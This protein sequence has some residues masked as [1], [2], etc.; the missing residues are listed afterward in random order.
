MEYNP[1]IELVRLEENFEYG[2]FGVLKINKEVFCPTLEPRDE[3]NSSFNS[4]IPAQ[5]YHCERMKTGL[6]SVLSLGL[7]NTFEVMNV[8]MRTNIKFHPGNSMEDT[9]GCILL[10][11]YFGKLRDKRAILNSGITFLEFMR[12]MDDHDRF[13]LTITEQY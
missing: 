13:N 4:C 1:I 12:R 6:T 9:A 11:Q 5:Q 10:G 2:T 8:P 7:T 3:L